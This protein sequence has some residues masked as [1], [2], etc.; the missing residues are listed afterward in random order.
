MLDFKKIIF[1]DN[2]S[3]TQVDSRVLEAMLPYFSEKYANAHSKHQFGSI[4]SEAIKKARFQVSELIGSEPHEIIFTSGATESINLALLGT[5][6]NYINK[7]KHIIT[8]TTE[9][10]AVIDTCKYLESLGFEVT[11]LPVNTDGTIDFDLLKS[12]IRRDTLLVSV[13]LANNETGVIQPLKEIGEYLKDREIIFLTDATQAVGKVPV[14]VDDLGVDLLCFSGHKLYGPKGIGTLFV[15]QHGKRIKVQPLIHGGGQERGLRSGTINVPGIVG[16]GFACH[17]SRLELNKNAMHI[18]SL[19]NY[20]ETEL[21]K[22]EGTHINGSIQNR[23]F[24]T[25]NITFRNV[26][27]DALIMGLNNPENDYLTAVSSGSACSSTNINPS[28][29]L[30]AMGL[31]EESAFSSIRFSIGKYNSQNE[32]EFVIN[33]IKKIIPELRN[34]IN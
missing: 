6:G 33:L 17:Y 10:Y 34:M 29:V 14:N 7:G 4:A 15:R 26:D 2:N 30:I 18:E 13:M 20:L 23:L 12:S 1:L 22:I 21:L 24:N 9:H 5:V 11:Y 31:N 16:L 8:V 3:T 28:H 32:I 27:S 19:R 25:S